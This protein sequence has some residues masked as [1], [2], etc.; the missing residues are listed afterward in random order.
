MAIARKIAYNIAFSATAKVLSTILALVGIGFITRYLGKE[1]FGDY[2]TAIAFFSFFAAIA[3]LGMYAVSTREI[4]RINAPEEK[5]IGNV[6]TLRIFST[7]FV[8]LVSPLIILFFPYPAEVK[9]AVLISS[10]AF[11]FASSYMVLNGV[12]QKNLAMYKV[13]AAELF[14]K[15]IQVGI[16]I[17]GALNNLGFLFI[18]TSLLVSMAVNFSVVYLLSR[19]Y[20]KFKIQFDFSY[21]KKFLRESLPM[22]ISVLVTFLYFKLDTILL[23]IMKGSAEVGIYN[24]AYK[25]IENITFFPAMIIG[26]VLPL[27]SRYIF[28][29]KEKFEAISNKVFKLFFILTVPLVVGTLFLAG[30]IIRLIGGDGFEESVPTLQ[31][32][33]FAMAFIFFGHLSNAVLLSGNL[34]KKLMIILSFCAVFNV[35]ANLIMIPLYS[36]TGAAITSVA[37]EILVVIAT[38]TLVVKKLS[39]KPK[40]E[41]VGR[42][43]ISGAVMAAVLYALRDVNFFLLAILAT[44]SYF[45]VLFLFRG[46]SKEEVASIMRRS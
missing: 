36:F 34:Q 23:S 24:A 8:F 31:I 9:L 17:Y 15:V 42:I 27:M 30:G 4:S 2:A 1:G 12:F 21:W 18:M 3:D 13:A 44:F 5:I 16:I 29:D 26:L 38:F 43:L 28:Y 22:G 41:N 33:I 6:F 45:A 19:K 11:V 39:Y 25:I 46:V 32:L 35:V 37:T 7:L 14:G 10:G 40:L 20:L